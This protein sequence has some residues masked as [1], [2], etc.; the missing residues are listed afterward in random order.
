MTAGPT[1]DY[2]A[3]AQDAMRG[4]V[5]TVLARAAKTGLPGDHHFYISF[6][7][8]QSGVVMSKRLKDKYPQEMTIVLQ[9]RFW[10]LAVT[11][12]RFEVKLTF[13]GIPERLVIPFNAIKVFFD[14]S[15]SYGLQFEDPEAA[16]RAGSPLDTEGADGR[17]TAIT[18]RSS[19][20]RKPRVPRARPRDG[21]A[22]DGEPIVRPAAEPAARS[23]P[24]RPALAPVPAPNGAG[25]S[26]VASP[27]HASGSA[28]GGRPTT[29]EQ[30][31]GQP[32]AADQKT[33]GHKTGEH[34][35]GEQKGEGKEKAPAGAELE[36]ANKPG[37][38]PAS[39]AQIV[40]LDAFRKK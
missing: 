18:T 16:A 28:H 31:G 20:P 3:L 12:E 27:A 2:D 9:H 21:E 25:S 8:Q 36:A 1:I 5:R 26:V 17:P 34:K 39:G 24:K 22:G 30:D 37:P 15:V 10:D 33:P 40:S 19:S 7:T 38:A 6:D 29:S 14:P 13:D 35:P 11:D 32:K 23:T 4:V